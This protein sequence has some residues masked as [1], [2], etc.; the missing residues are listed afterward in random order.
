MD[1]YGDVS[2]LVKIKDN[3]PTAELKADS[4][5]IHNPSAEV[6]SALK[7]FAVTR[8]E[9]VKDDISFEDT[10]KDTIA[11]RMPEATFEELLR[12]L[13]ITSAANNKMTETLANMFQS[14]NSDKTIIERLEDRG[15]EN[16]AAQL[17]ASTNNKNDIQALTYLSMI[18]GKAQTQG[19]QDH[20]IE[21]Q[22]EEVKE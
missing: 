6:K 9:K 14:Q 7:D 11:L 17:Y 15:T 13:A 16:A 19:L 1:K 8:L 5:R 4:V 3:L 21:T 12:L 20:T 10:I 22:A 2:T 18:L